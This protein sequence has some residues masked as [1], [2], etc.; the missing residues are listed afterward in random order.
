LR[1]H[2]K[3]AKEIAHAGARAKVAQALRAPREYRRASRQPN[4]GYRP[5][6]EDFDLAGLEDALRDNVRNSTYLCWRPLVTPRNPA[7]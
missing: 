6:R 5:L 7:R 2:R 1:Q 4:P 3:E